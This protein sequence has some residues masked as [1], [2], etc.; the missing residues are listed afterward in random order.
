MRF[1]MTASLI[2][3]VSIAAL[4][5]TACAQAQTMASP[6]AAAQ[7]TTA[8]VDDPAADRTEGDI[9]VT[10]SKRSERLVDV[11]SSVTAIS[12]DTLADANATKL[13]DY[14]ARIPGLVADNV[15][16][17]NGA[18]QLTIRGL[19]TGTGGNPTVGIYIDDAPYGGSSTSTFGGSTVPDLDPQDLQRV[20]VLRGPQGTL[21]G[22]GSLGG[23]FKYVTAAPDPTRVLGRVQ[24]DG[25]FVDR[26]GSGY[27]LRG[28]I[29]VPLTGPLAMR[30]SAYYRRDPGYVDNVTTGERDVND[31]RFYGGRVA[32]GARLG[33]NFTIRAAAIVQKQTA[34]GNAITDYT[35]T[36]RTPR[37]GELQQARAPGTGRTAQF[38]SDYSITMEGDMGFAALTSATSYNRQT[39]DFNLDV[40]SSYGAILA[41][42]GI[43]NAGTAIV[44]NASL[45]KI[46]QEVR[47]TSPT[48]QVISWQAGGFFTNEQ[49]ATHQFFSNF[50]ASTGG[51]YPATIPTLLDAR[52]NSR[53]EEIAAFGDVTVAFSP[54]FDI[55]GGIRY[56]HNNQ[57]RVQA[58]AGALLGNS[59]VRGKS[60]DNSTTYLLTPRF[61]FGGSNTLY[62]RFATGYRPG[63]PNN[64]VP[65][66][67]SSYGPDRTT[68][69]EIGFKTLS[70]DRRLSFDIA[71]F[72]IDWKDIQLNE[73]NAQGLNFN[74]NGGTARSRGVEAEANWRPIDGLSIDGSVAF[75]DAVLT[76]DLPPSSTVGFKGDRLP[77]VPR[78][79]GQISADY[80]FA[81]SAAVRPVLGASW[82]YIGAREGYFG[83]ATVGRFHLPAYDV[84]DLRAGI[85]FERI[86]LTGFVKNVGNSRGKVAAYVLGPDFR[87]AVIQP[88]TFGIS[89][90][91]SF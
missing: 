11:P 44:T 35:L 13:E 28:A 21:Y 89:L 81:S 20:E 69:Y 12:G 6:P 74:G 51:A 30:A 65:G 64:P 26:G 67:P 7:D 42:L 75:T 10:A 15:S 22:A 4:A 49:G 53:F 43:P 46:T 60:S 31:A 59:T 33:D 71:G 86:S 48:N 50:L 61:R 90:S 27:G 88:R 82:R 1:K 47:V 66:T 72:W 36:T 78:W 52:V 24:A 56:S 57:Q 18:T 55:T 39:V 29:N 79:S 2:A 37:F 70:A 62:A 23:L 17:S 91:D 54:A 14:V 32:L 9:V 76:Q 25:Q 40:T 19:N 87:V 34:D 80:D 3:T 5:Q 38:V 45:D 83:T 84:F 8:Q 16:F 77:S 58:N 63:G 73:R 41:G 68:N 85:R